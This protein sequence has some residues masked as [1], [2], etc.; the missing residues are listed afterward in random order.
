MLVLAN[1][2]WDG[3]VADDC[4]RR[5]MRINRSPRARRH[6]ELPRIG[7]RRSPPHRRRAFYTTRRPAT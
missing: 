2:T 5:G 3:L 1:L 7:R 4:Y 6:R